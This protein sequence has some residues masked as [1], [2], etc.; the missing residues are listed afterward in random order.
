MCA[1]A[2]AAPHRNIHKHFLVIYLYALMLA[3]PEKRRNSF[4]SDRL[5][6]VFTVQQ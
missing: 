4:F 3:G 6:R 1:R 5:I 2:A